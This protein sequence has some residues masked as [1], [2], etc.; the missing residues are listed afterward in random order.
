MT[1]HAIS[2][3]L[4]SCTIADLETIHSLFYN[5]QLISCTKLVIPADSFVF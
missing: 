1:T 2:S 3:V 5:S 4:I